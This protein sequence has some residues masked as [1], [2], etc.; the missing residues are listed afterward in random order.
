[1][2]LNK[3]TIQWLYRRNPDGTAVQGYTWNYFSGCVH[4]SEACLFCYA[5]LLAEQK[6]GTKAFPNG[7]DLTYRP[8]KLGDPLKVKTGAFIFVDSMSDLW[9]EPVPDTEIMKVF[10]VMEKAHW[11]TFLILTKRAERMVDW[12]NRHYVQAN[13]PFPKNINLGVTVES[14]KHVNRAEL[15]LKTPARVKWLSVEPLLGPLVMPEDMLKQLHQ[16]VVGGE[17]GNRNQDIRLM[18]PDWARSLRDQCVEAGVPFF[19]K[20]WG[21]YN[22][23]G[24]RVGKKRAGRLLDGREWNEMPKA[25]EPTLVSGGE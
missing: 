5:R 24:I 22:A 16:I 12:I 18:H 14:Q 3:T 19:F 20:Q 25:S 4:A 21:G 9:F 2:A 10:E 17:S 6:R 7:F 1:M 23:D 8:H 15:L 13:R 11:H